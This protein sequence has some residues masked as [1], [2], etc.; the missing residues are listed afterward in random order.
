MT[1]GAW[2]WH[3]A[4]GYVRISVEGLKL[5]AFLSDAAAQGIV[6]SNVSR[7]AYSRLTAQVNYADY[8]RLCKLAH[9]RPLRVAALSSG[10]VPKLWAMALQ[11]VVFSVGL[12]LCMA[13]LALINAFVLQVRVLGC[14]EPAL[15]QQVLEAAA[16]YGVRPGVSKSELDLHEAERQMLLQMPELSFVAIRVHGVV[17]N[18]EVVP[19]Q[20]PP[21]LLD[22]D[23]PCDIVAARDAV[24]RRVVVY[25]GQPLVTVDNVVR[26]GQVLVSSLEQWADGVHAVHAR[27]D[28]YASVWAEG[29]GS[30]PLFNEIVEPTGVF[31]QSRRVDFGGYSLALDAGGEPP[32]EDYEVTVTERPLLGMGAKGP[33]LIVTR[34]EEVRRSREPRDAELA[35]QEAMD[36]AEQEAQAQLL[37]DAQVVGQRFLVESTQDKVLARLFIEILENIACEAPA[38]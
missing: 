27:A 9:N 23:T 19:A 21:K 11:R 18:V 25:A 16:H 12:V 5:M 28:V 2:I 32:F 17:A 24:V 33:R 15:E 31:A 4:T 1:V 6:L 35:K 36:Q 3:F 38:R 14:E 37:P 26:R 7:L 10:G 22:S 34:Y 13:A 29:R 8:R 20:M 30:A